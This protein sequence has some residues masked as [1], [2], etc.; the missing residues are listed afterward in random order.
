MPTAF[1]DGSLKHPGTLLGLGSFGIWEPGREYATTM[2]EEHDFCRPL[3]LTR[4]HKLNGVLMAGTLSGVYNS[5]TRA[6]L[7]GVIASLPKPGGLHIA[8]DNRSVVDRGNAIFSGAF[9]SRKPWGLLNDG[10]LWQSFDDAIKLRGAHSVALTWTKGHSSWQRIASSYSHANAIGNSIADAAADHGYEAAGKDDIHYVLEHHAAKHR[11]FGKLIGRLQVFA[12]RLL[13]HDSECRR[14][15]GTDTRSKNLVIFIDAPPPTPR[16]DFIEGDSL[17]LH[18]LPP[19]MLESHE[20]LHVF[21]G[22]HQMD[23]F[24][25]L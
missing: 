23:P 25:N 6:E 8:L 20:G 1:S 10:D 7:A 22:S 13:L 17:Y 2:P 4:A 14:E 5:S 24:R 11:S 21:L 3:G 9:V 19:D 12:A 18:P 15:A 16:Q